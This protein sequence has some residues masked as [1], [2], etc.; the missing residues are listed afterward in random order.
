VNTG[1]GERA[2]AIPEDGATVNATAART[3][4]TA[5]IAH[6]DAGMGPSAPGEG[7]YE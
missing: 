6:R 4:V 5:A 3:I 7:G 2:V 1:P